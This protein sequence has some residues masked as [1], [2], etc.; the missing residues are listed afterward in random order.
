[1]VIFIDESG[2]HTQTGHATTAVVYITISNLDKVEQKILK[3]EKEIK[4]QTFHWGEERW[5]VRNKFLAKV[6]ELDFVV[7]IAIF[8]N[9]VHPERMI[10]VVFQHLITEENI[11]NIFI[12]GKKPRWYENK[13]KKVLRDKGIAVKKL[14]AVRSRSRP[15]IQLADALAGLI[16]RYFDNPEEEYPKK[17]FKKL[18]K[19]K[20]IAGQF[21]FN[22][23]AV[24]KL[25]AKTHKKPHRKDGVS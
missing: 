4:I 1:M 12:D 7:K 23:E 15:G 11:K 16:R 10:E 9:P 6:L 5:Q 17:W 18:D 25:L 21:L 2:T 22:A 3:A 13:L 14:R 8:E 20:K 19:E 24:E